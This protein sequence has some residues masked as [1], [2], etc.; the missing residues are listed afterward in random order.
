MYS[1]KTVGLCRAIE[2][3]RTMGSRTCRFTGRPEATSN[4]DSDDVAPKSAWGSAMPATDGPAESS[5]KPVY[6]QLLVY[7]RLTA[8]ARISIHAKHTV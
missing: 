3:D 5:A 6:G 7:L 2:L 4:A 1:T 8:E